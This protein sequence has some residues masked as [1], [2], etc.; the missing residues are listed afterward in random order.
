MSLGRMTP[1][2]GEDGDCKGSRIDGLI[3][4][5]TFEREHDHGLAALVSPEPKDLRERIS[6]A[7]LGR[8]IKIKAPQKLHA[9][10]E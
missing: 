5:L 10:G 6:R 9:F 8:F 3:L 4:P 1:K 7:S 2:L